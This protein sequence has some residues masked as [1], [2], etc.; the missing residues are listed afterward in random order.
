MKRKHEATLS[1]FE[2]LKKAYQALEKEKEALELSNAIIEGEKKDFENKVSE[3]EAQKS[4]T[5]RKAKELRSRVGD[6]EAQ[7][8]SLETQ[9]KIANE[10]QVYITP[11]QEKAFLIRRKIY[12]V[13][14]KLVEEVYKIKQA[15]TRLK[16]IFAL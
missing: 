6:M 16:E 5:D 3:L 14:L 8:S 7:N 15:E 2:R 9:L 12:Q 10:R 4:V 13:Q 11:F 1:Q